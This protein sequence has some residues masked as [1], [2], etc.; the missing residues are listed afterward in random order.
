[1]RV[2]LLS[3]LVLLAGCVGSNVPYHPYKQPNGREPRPEQEVRGDPVREQVEIRHGVPHW[4]D[5][6][7]VYIGET[8]KSHQEVLDHVNRNP[9]DGSVRNVWNAYA[10]DMNGTLGAG[11]VREAP[12]LLPKD[13]QML[14]RSE[15]SGEGAGAGDK[16]EKGD[17]G[18][19]GGE[20]G[21]KGGDKGMGDK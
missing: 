13:Q 14:K 19:K 8:R 21:D 12:K 2:A 6:D 5:E 4:V 18:D 15:E 7:T 9:N 16:G 3:I 20:K 11:T 17:K 10:S 1:M